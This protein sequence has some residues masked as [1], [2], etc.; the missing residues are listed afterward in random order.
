M[1]PTKFCKKKFSSEK[2]EIIEVMEYDT[3]NYS[4]T[5]ETAIT[6]TRQSVV[7]WLLGLFLMW[8]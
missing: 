2:T 4:E 6:I 1:T 3:F 8:I 5:D 7:S